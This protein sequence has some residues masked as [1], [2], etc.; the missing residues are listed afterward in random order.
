MDIYSPRPED[1]DAVP[2]GMGI[3]QFTD[4][5]PDVDNVGLGHVQK[6]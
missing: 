2:L 1:P 6:T 4:S 5:W 3:L